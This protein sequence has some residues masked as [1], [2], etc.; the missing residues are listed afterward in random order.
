VTAETK[1]GDARRRSLTMRKHMRRMLDRSTPLSWIVA[2]G[3]A[4]TGIAACTSDAVRIGF[5]ADLGSELGVGGRNGAELAV[6]TLNAQGRARY[7]LLVESDR[8]D[9][10]VAQS[11]VASLAARNTTF[12]VGPMTSTMAVAAVPEANRVGLVMISPTA[13][14]DELSG[15]DDF[16]FRTAADASTGARQ[17]ARVLHDRGLRSVLVL[18]DIA[19]GAYSSSFGHAVAM[20][21]LRLG[22]TSA[23][24]LG[25]WSGKSL[26]FASALARV[27]AQAPDAVVLVDNPTDAGIASQH[28]RRTMPQVAIALSPWGANAQYLQVGGR[29]SEGAIALQAVD[30]DSTLAPMRTFVDRYR[31]RFGEAPTTP[32]VQAY[33]AVML[34]VDAL[35]RGGGAKALRA[36]LSQPGSRHGLDGDFL[37]DAHGDTQRALRLTRVHDG[38]F[39][40]LSK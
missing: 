39:E 38:R 23:P 11:A 29:A 3:C 8:N 22:G 13:T 16:F 9:P 2:A 5:I 40:A 14:T 12:V 37:M 6:S 28:L 35:D 1:A 18:M 33:E 4:L 7:E 10:K 21:F 32:A 15:K 36:T 25:Y 17:L 20:E 31:E 24:E 26:D 34:G 30:L 27:D 19:N